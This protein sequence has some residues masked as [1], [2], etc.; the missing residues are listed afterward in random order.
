MVWGPRPLQ[1]EGLRLHVRG[2][3]KQRRESLGQLRL[4]QS[5]QGRKGIQGLGQQVR[6]LFLRDK[7]K[8]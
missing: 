4:A 3:R 2:D 8:F 6:G 7:S 5:S 1:S